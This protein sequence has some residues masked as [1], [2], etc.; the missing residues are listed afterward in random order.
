MVLRLDWIATAPDARFL[1]ER[2]VSG[3]LVTYCRAVAA[4]TPTGRNGTRN[5]QASEVSV[6]EW[7]TPLRTALRKNT[8]S[9][10]IMEFSFYGTFPIWTPRAGPQIYHF[11][12]SVSP[13][14]FR[15]AFHTY[16]YL[17]PQHSPHHLIVNK[18]IKYNLHDIVF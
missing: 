18:I 3:F 11:A 7:P 4:W 8:I 14:H 9:E 2:R 1:I 10:I 13:A 16:R 6:A 15:R 12:S 5:Y 17:F